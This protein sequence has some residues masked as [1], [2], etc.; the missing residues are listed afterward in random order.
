MVEHTKIS[1]IY[2]G[3][4]GNHPQ[5]RQERIKVSGTTG[6]RKIRSGTWVEGIEGRET[7]DVTAGMP[8]IEIRSRTATTTTKITKEETNTG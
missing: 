6:S 1:N 7:T 8:T 5:R 3:E 4:T 2:H